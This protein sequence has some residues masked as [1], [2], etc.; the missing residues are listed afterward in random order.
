MKAA[1]E[2]SGA[3]KLGKKLRTLKTTQ[4]KGGVNTENTH[5]MNAKNK[6]RQLLQK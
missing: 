5:T 1:C 3:Q 2:E 4:L 6:I